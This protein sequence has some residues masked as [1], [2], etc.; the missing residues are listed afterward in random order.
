M[1]YYFCATSKMLDPVSRLRNP[2]NFHPV[3]ASRYV[4]TCTFLLQSTLNSNYIPSLN[5]T[6]LNI[7]LMA[8]LL[9][10]LSHTSYTSSKSL[11]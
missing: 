7:P 11:Y 6:F 4:C 8:L 2:P 5:E 10:C 9:S 3:L 1:L